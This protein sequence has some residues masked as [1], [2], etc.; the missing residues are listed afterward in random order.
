[1]IDALT[2]HQIYLQRYFAGINKDIQPL[3]KAL[4]KDLNARIATASDNELNRIV[5]LKRELELIARSHTDKINTALTQQLI[6]FYDYESQF[7]VKLLDEATIPSYAV[8]GASLSPEMVKATL[9][10]MPITLDGKSMT[11]K[12]MITHFGMAQAKN[13]ELAINTG[14]VEGKT[15]NQIVKDIK[16]ML[17]TRTKRQAEAV[18][19]TAANATGNKAR[20]E[21]WAANA[22]ILEGEEYCATLDARVT[23]ICSSLDGNVYPVGTGPQPPLHYRCRSLMVPKLKEQ[24]DLKRDRFRSSVDGPVNAKTTY[25]Q[26]LRRQ[27]KAF[28]E[29]VLGV[30]RAKLF[31]EGKVSL[32][33]FVDKSGKVLTLEQLKR[34][35]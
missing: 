7:T 9:S 26:F 33:G 35:N 19:L 11:V 18:I 3:I 12:E 34:L 8:I 10:T 24:F 1:M 25:E 6:D 4:I 17:G 20:A 30:E 15:T 16:S 21:V 14:L 27:D 29:E 13:I 23:L 31:R 2:R 28:Q 5:I 22:D 32:D